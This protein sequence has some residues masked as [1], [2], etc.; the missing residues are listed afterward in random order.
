[1]ACLTLF[2]IVFEHQVPVTIIDLRRISPCFQ[3]YLFYTQEHFWPSLFSSTHIWICFILL[4]QKAFW[5]FLVV[6]VFILLMFIYKISKV[7]FIFFL[8]INIWDSCGFA[9]NIINFHSFYL[10]H[11]TQNVIKHV[12]IICSVEFNVVSS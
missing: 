10:H 7:I 2:T 9:C 12:K 11:C 6:F 4:L 3:T 1:M 8:N 5:E